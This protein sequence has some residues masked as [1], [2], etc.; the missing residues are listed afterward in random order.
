MIGPS[1]T[2]GLEEFSDF[3]QRVK[4]A[5][6]HVES[7]KFLNYPSQIQ[8]LLEKQP[9]WFKAKWSDKVLKFQRKKGKDAFPPFEEF[10]EEVRYHAERT[11]IPQILHGLGAT[12]STIPDRNKHLGR[13]SGRTRSSNVALKSTSTPVDDS[14][15]T[16]SHEESQVAAIQVQQPSL[17]STPASNSPSTCQTTPPNSGTYCFYHKMKS[18]AMNDCEQFQKL[19]YEERKDFLMKNRICLKCVSS[20]KHVSK[21]C[22]RNK[23]QCKICQQKHATVL[24]DPTRH[25]K[26]DASRVNSA[27]SQ[28]CR[29]NQSAR[30]C[31]R[32]VLLEV[33][34]QDN[35]SAKVPIYTVLDDQSTDVFIADSL[36]EQLGVQ[37]QEVNMEI[38][39]ITG[40]NSVRTQKVNGLHIQD[41][42]SL[43][44]SIK[45]P[46][47]YSQ[48]K[49][50]ASQEDIATPEIARSWKHLE[51]IARQIHH[52]TDITIGLLIGRNIPSVF[53]PLRIIYGTDNEPWAVESISSVGQSLV[54]CA[55]TKRKIVQ[56]VRQSTAS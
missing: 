35:P 15:A 49:I 39:T 30:S 2:V 42:E 17:M 13:Q 27:C 23:L 21:D 41:M 6:K 31:A 37:G 53:Q 9:G 29:R 22:S 51:G 28:V 50:P 40:I 18:H 44:K 5:N 26:E 32:I 8:V 55:S 14:A 48:E 1:D 19:S 11:N 46:F 33:F 7:L 3:L 20:N 52:R 10:T 47:A 16:P 56:T 12:G 24:H 45:V 34:H 25:K 38:N 54:L 4:I 43:H 36:L